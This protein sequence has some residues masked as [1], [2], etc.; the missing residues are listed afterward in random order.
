[1]MTTW[2]VVSVRYVKD[3]VIPSRHNKTM[4]IACCNEGPTSEISSD[5]ADAEYIY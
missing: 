3:N 4:F 2:K 1:M 5:H